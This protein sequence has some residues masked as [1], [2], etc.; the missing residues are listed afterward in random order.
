M[1][2]KALL[3]AALITGAAGGA[4]AQTIPEACQTKTPYVLKFPCIKF[5]KITN[6]AKTKLFPIVFSGARGADDWLRS[7]YG[8][9]A[10]QIKKDKFETEYTYRSYVI[11]DQ[12][13]E[14]GETIY[15]QVPFYSALV[16]NPDPTKKDQYVDWW[17]GGRVFLYDDAEQVKEDYKAPNQKLVTPATPGLYWCTSLNKAE[18][19]CVAPHPL[20]LFAAK[21]G[22]PPTDLSQLTEFTFADAVTANGPPFPLFLNKVGYN[23]SSVDQTYLPVAMQPFGNPNIP[24]IGTV[25][26][27]DDFRDRMRKFLTD[28]PGWPVYLPQDES[29]PRIPGAYNVYAA[30][31]DLTPPGEAVQQMDELYR[32]C[33]VHQPPD[34]TAVCT[35]YRDVVALMQANYNAFVKLKCHDPA[36]EFTEAQVIKRVYGWVSFNEGCGAGANSLVSTVGDKKLAVL[37]HGY[38]AN[39]QYSTTEPV[40]NPYVSLIHDPKYLDEAAY[41]FSIDD[42]IGFQ[43]YKGTG[44][45]LAYAGAGGL[46]NDTKLDIRDRVTVTLGAPPKGQPK[47]GA[48]GLCS[49]TANYDEFIDGFPSIDFFPSHYPCR[50][51]AATTDGTLYQFAIKSAPQSAKGLT[52]ACPDNVANPAWCAGV[53]VVGPQQING[54]PPP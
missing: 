28:F 1:Q 47:W 50:F 37:E 24:Y 42:A 41:A 35:Q 51:T 10:E 36:I 18:T 25:L 48:Y 34:Q 27:V 40:Y 29:R 21:E 2:K 45:I 43:S 33:N 5:I 39:M 15:V 8:L 9:N 53:Q 31:V 54:P 3:V 7:L 12:G 19:A 20:N 13:L 23:I 26:G 49:S 4:M 22:F 30:K 11:E 6:N 14:P 38:I 52:V 44:L 32:K 17:N 46:D 16:S